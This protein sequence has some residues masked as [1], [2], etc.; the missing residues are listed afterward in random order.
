MHWLIYEEN[1]NKNLFKYLEN[2]DMSISSDIS[3]INF[4]QK[5]NAFG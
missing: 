5:T 3:F 4:G 2:T 1:L